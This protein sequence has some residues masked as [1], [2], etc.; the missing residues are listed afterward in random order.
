MIDRPRYIDRIMSF[1][2]KPLI[3]VISGMRRSG[4]STLLR[5]VMEELK[6]KGVAEQ[7]I[8]YINKELIEFDAIRTHLDL[9]GW[10]KSAGQ[11]IPGRLYFFIDE[12]QEIDQWER[13]VNSILAE[14]G[15][16][17][18]ITGSNSRLLASELST[19]IAGRYVEIP[20][21]PL[22]FSEFLKFRE[23]DSTKDDLEDEFSRYLRYGG[24]PGIHHLP[25]D[26]EVVF[27]YLQAMTSTILL[28][29]VVARYS[30]R[31]VPLLERI[32]A[33][34]FDNCG[35]VTSAKRIRDY[36]KNQQLRLGVDTVQNYLHYFI[37]AHM[38]YRCK[39]YDI[40]GKRHLELYEKYYPADLGMRHALLRYRDADIGQ[41]LETVVYHELL[42]RGWFVSVGKMDEREVDF[43]A[44]GKGEKM[45]IQ[46]SYLLASSETV[47]REFAVLRSIPD[48]FP[49]IVLSMDKT[50]SRQSQ[51]GIM[52]MN[53]IDFLL[54]D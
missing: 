12:V 52:R 51:E 32:A 13:A 44:E 29:D 4:K 17:I 10:F 37:D 33:F 50:W 48:H 46:V 54:G 26:D 22:S 5:L 24:F 11:G 34:V 7:Q 25:Q 45:Y 23:K 43:I 36:L 2:D 40:K 39:R 8:L 38:V 27:Q 19:L 42:R 14:D 49:K 35:Q 16:D 3:K 21:Y 20:L 30:V 28:K 53:I 41:I 31:D 1:A 18:F 47:E 9:A 6:K 15:A